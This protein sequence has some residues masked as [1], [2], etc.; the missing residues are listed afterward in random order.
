MSGIVIRC[1]AIAG[2]RQSVAA[3]I[4]GQYLAAIDLPAQDR[5]I[6]RVAEWTPD[7][8]KAIPYDTFRDA[9][10]AWRQVREDRPVRGDGLPNRPLTLFTV[11]FEETP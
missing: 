8:A 3:E 4:T 6:F 9:F 2:L 7:P 5:D 11:T 1:E 10:E